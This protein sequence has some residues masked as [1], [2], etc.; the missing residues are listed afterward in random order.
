MNIKDGFERYLDL[1]FIF[2][3]NFIVT[4][5]S[6]GNGRAIRVLW[7]IRESYELP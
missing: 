7:S 3:L 6:C 2:F 5:C 4:P 1:D